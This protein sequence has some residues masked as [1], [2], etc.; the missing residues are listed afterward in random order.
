MASRLDLQIMLETLLESRNVYFQPPESV[1]IN[2]PAII[3]GL[4]DIKNTFADDG[5][6][7]SHKRYA[8]T[9]IDKNPD[10]AFVD[11]LAKLSA[12]RFNRHYKSENLNHWVFS[13]Y[14]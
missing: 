8:V 3:Y 9:L 1:K 2:Y 13:L 6:Y 11:K 12:C 7:L 10:S 4:D 14:F 5:V